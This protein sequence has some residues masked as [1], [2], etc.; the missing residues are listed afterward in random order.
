MHHWATQG[1]NYYVLARLHW[2][3]DVNVDEII[4]DYCRSGFGPAA[5]PI[6]RYFTRIEQL[7]NEVAA[8]TQ[9]QR[10]GARPDVTEPYTQQVVGELR[11]LLDEADKA[12]DNTE[13]RQRISFLR[14]GLD[15][16]EL[17]AKIY[18][19]LKLDAERRLS[20]AEQAQARRLLD[21]K[22]LIMR[23]IFQ[24]E[25]FAVNVSAICWGEWGRFKRL[26]WNGPSQ[27]MVKTQVWLSNEGVV[28]GT[29]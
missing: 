16:T 7:T 10:D 28:S 12:A 22:W 14:L 5:G 19:L 29:H 21:E 1:L 20:E 15:F 3:P 11:E 26:G 8:V 13:V 4:D 17:Q 27:E 24:E 2:N 25:H 23:R 18:R 9:K 6:K